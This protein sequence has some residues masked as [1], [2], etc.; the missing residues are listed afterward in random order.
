MLSYEVSKSI[1]IHRTQSETID[2]LKD[3]TNWREWSPWLILE[4][5][6][7]LTYSEEQGKVGSGYQ[8]NGK[9]I[10]TGAVVLESTQSHR[11]D[12]E[13]HFFRPFQSHA[14]VTFIV[15]PSSN[16][17]TVEWQMQSRVPWFLV[18]FKSMF[19][20]MIEMDFDRG[21]RMLKSQ[22]ENGRVLSKLRDLGSRQQNE[23]NYIG[24]AGAGTLSEIGPVMEAHITRL[25]ELA[26]KDNLPVTGELFCYYLSM[27]IK[28]N[29]FEFITCLPVQAGVVATGEFVAGTI[30][31]SETYVVEH[32]G[33]YWFLGNAWSYAM[34]LTRHNG[35]KVKTKPLGIER[36]LN[37]PN[38][39]DK[40]ELLTEVIVFKK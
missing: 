17:C 34:N 33:D 27:D 40:A 12:M 1:E 11:L 37:D 2:Y 8:W 36:Y 23:I 4:P 20:A 9:R 5:E 18:F 31:A 32:K 22:L 19:K 15:M 29:Y 13:L 26:G 38:E 24:L 10:G 39:T 35:I 25:F 16:G 6:C 3:Y 28:R 14:K 21:L 7:E 30:P